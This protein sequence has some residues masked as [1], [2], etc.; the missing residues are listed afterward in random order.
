MSKEGA[1]IALGVLVAFTPF[2]G[3]PGAWKS[4]LYATLG[5]AIASLAYLL[6]RELLKNSEWVEAH[7]KKATTF[8]ENAG[9]SFSSDV[10]PR[11]DEK[12]D[13]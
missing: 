7:K 12:K 13:I 4:V 11:T 1:L 3:L 5:A 6:R 10:T 8:T 2:F 9:A